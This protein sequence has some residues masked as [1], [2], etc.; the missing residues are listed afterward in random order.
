[1][2]NGLLRKLADKSLT[3]DE[4]RQKVE[5]DFSLL[6]ILLDG[7]SS[8]K[9]AIRYGCAK[10]LM[11]LSAEYPEKLEFE[12]KCKLLRLLHINGPQR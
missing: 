3:K 2:E 10:I 11:D 6:P 9:A 8:P 1:M 7:V 5:Q 12:G 4:L